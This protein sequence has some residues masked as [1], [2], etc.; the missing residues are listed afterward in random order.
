MKDTNTII[1]AVLGAL[2]IGGAGFFIGSHIHAGLGRG[3]AIGNQ[4]AGFRMGFGKGG[5]MD[6]D[7]AVKGRIGGR[8]AMG[9][10]G[11]ITKIDGTNVTLKYADGTTK[12]VTLSSDTVVNTMTKG[13]VKDLKVGATIMVIGGG[14]W[15]STDIV[16]VRP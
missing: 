11:E 12:D 8:G 9:N 6:S 7:D 1:F 3:W 15:N 2:I 16:I 5:M 13:T 4:H 10:F 14:F